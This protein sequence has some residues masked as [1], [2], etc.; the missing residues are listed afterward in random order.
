MLSDIG[1]YYDMCHHSLYKNKA[2]Y[3]VIIIC[4][5]HKLWSTFNKNS[6]SG[7][8]FVYAVMTHVIVISYIEQHD[9]EPTTRA[10][11]EV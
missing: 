8:V 10:S 3:G 11:S 9:V 1:N 7:F 2:L 4:I 6:K 5:N